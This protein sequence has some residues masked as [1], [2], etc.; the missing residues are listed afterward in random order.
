LFV[1]I[2]ICS[3]TGLPASFQSVGSQEGNFPVFEG[4][5]VYSLRLDHNISNNN[6]LM[7]RSNVSPSTVTGIEVSGEDQ[8]FGQNA[9]SRTSEQ[10][11]RDVAG[12]AQDTWTFGNNKVNQFLFQYARRG[13]SYYYNT[14][15]PGGS[16]PAVNIP[17]FAYFGREPYSY[18]QRVENRY[19]FK[20]DFSW[21]I[22]RHATKFGVDFNYIPITATFT[23]N[24]GGVYDFG[25]L[26]AVNALPSATYAVLQGGVPS[27]GIPGLSA[28]QSYG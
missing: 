5:S 19:Q 12:V 7:L 21:S 14:A 10:T 17:G 4:T 3:T 24:Y 15:I 11:F 28:V 6:R 2:P 27:V 26:S 23:V 18:I 8:P 13:L 16:D 20:D 22:G 9:Y 1:P 25:S